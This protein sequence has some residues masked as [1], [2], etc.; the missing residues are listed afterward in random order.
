MNEHPRERAHNLAMAAMAEAAGL[1]E[2]R[3][4]SIR[5]GCYS[6]GQVYAMV[7]DHI[8][9]RNTSAVKIELPSEYEVWDGN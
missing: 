3:V 1:P 9:Q 7:R 4:E 6:D 5:Q 8:D 2:E